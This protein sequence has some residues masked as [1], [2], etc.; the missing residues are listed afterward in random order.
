MFFKSFYGGNIKFDQYVMC[1]Y[2]HNFQYCKRKFGHL[3]KHSEIRNKLLTNIR[4]CDI[5]NTSKEVI[6]KECVTN[7]AEASVRGRVRIIADKEALA[8]GGLGG[9]AQYV[10]PL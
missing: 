10:M 2:V 6:G 5:I 8:E 3:H 7:V 1:H 4:K 9:D